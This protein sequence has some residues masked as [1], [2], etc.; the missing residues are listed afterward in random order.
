MVGLRTLTGAFEKE[1]SC[2]VDL[3]IHSIQVR[4]YVR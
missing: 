3:N 1:T 2:V 4:T